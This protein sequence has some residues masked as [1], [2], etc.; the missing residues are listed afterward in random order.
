MASHDPVTS[1]LLQTFEEVRSR[2]FAR[3]EGLTDAR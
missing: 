3:L 2:T 1:D